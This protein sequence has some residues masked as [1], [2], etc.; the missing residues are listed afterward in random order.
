MQHVF[1]ERPVAEAV[2]AERE[3]RGEFLGVGDLARRA[4][5]FRAVLVL[6]A[7]GVPLAGTTL[8]TSNAT[9]GLRPTASLTAWSS[10]AR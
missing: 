1:G 6:D 10:A 9:S 5:Q 2:V 4:G 8:T 3:A 7:A